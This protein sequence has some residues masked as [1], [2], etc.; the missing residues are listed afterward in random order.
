MPKGENILEYQV[1]A[2]GNSSLP[3]TAHLTLLPHLGETLKASTGEEAKLGDS[4]IHW[5]PEQIGGS[6]DY[7]G[8]RVRVP[9]GAS[10]H[11]PALPHNPYRKDGHA[12]PSEARIEIRIPLEEAGRARTVTFE[13]LESEPV[14]EGRAVPQ[15]QDTL[16]S[17]GHRQGGA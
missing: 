1:E 9:E 10:L 8:Y 5:T 14:R 12:N 2:T 15:S 16:W 13:I 4:E 3:V 7:A 11:W 17:P 6:F